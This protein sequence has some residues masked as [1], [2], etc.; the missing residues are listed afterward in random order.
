MGAAIAGEYRAI[1]N[2]LMIDTNHDAWGIRD[3][4][5]QESSTTISDIPLSADVVSAYLYWSGWYHQG[6]PQPLFEDD[7]ADFGEWI[8][9]SSWNI[10]SGHFRSHYSSGAESTRY[11]SLN[12]NYDLSAY[13][14]IQVSWEQWE[15]GT[16]ESSDALKFQFS[17]DG[18]TTWSS[19]FTAFANDIGSS[20]QSF[21]Y[22][23]PGAYLTDEFTFRFYLQD[24]SGDGEYCNID[25]FAINQI[26]YTADTSVVF[27]INGAQVYLDGN[28]DPQLGSQETT[29]FRW[30]TLEN[31][32]GQYSYA[33]FRDVTTLVREYSDMGP[34]DNPTGNGIYTVGG[35]DAD[36]GEHWSYAGWSLIVIY[37][38]PETAG[39]QLYLF[40]TFSYA[41]TDE[42]LDF[43]DDGA[44]GGSI[45]GFLIPEPVAGEQNAA[46]LTAF[47]G[48]G[49]QC[50][51]GDY[52]A[53]NG[54][55]MSDG[56]GSLTNVWDSQSV[57][58]SED[59]VDIDNFYVTWAS[60]LLEPGDSSAQLDIQT[61][62]D[63]W[64]LIYLILS[65]RS[66]T[67]NNGTRHYV[68]RNR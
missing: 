50:W 54:T 42:N 6:T 67:T 7:C 2:S 14:R 1:G 20:P 21:S 61:F 25:N 18:G 57:G 51:T 36:T 8:P 68:I 23:I 63:N 13:E 62:I 45:T 19:L 46:T 47:V 56:A 35:V 3:V 43:D 49:D 15:E 5:L 34:D 66:E 40:D 29:A 27:K 52:L 30:S 53:F 64:N 58:M 22:M 33:C 28:G 48:E 60:G 59:G 9:G 65:V 41:N 26:V 39:H 4:V 16:L 38:S 12:D 37:S 55:R 24:F 32:T 44:P 11:L 31:E 10:D 17:G